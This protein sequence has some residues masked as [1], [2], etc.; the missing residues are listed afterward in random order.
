MAPDTTHVS[1]CEGLENIPGDR[2][3]LACTG[4]D[5]L[6]C[7]LLGRQPTQQLQIQVAFLGLCIGVI[8]NWSYE[9]ILSPLSL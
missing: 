2:T 8:K 7:A 1:L 9:S 3:L 4:P 6:F 5:F